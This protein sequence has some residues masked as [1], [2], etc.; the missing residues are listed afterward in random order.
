MVLLRCRSVYVDR[1]LMD[2]ER[3]SQLKQDFRQK[4]QT[5]VESLRE[6]VSTSNGNWTI[7]EFIDIL[8]NIYTISGDTKVVSKI[9]ELH[10]L[11]KIFEFADQ[12]GY[13]IVLPD[14]QN[15]Y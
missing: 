4:L 5:F 11:L 13:K 7:K 12:S 14:H 1:Q 10:L 9:I 3:R 15:Y 6:F 8:Q 2:L